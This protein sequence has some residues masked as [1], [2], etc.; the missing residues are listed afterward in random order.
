[1][2]RTT[3]PVLQLDSQ[4]RALP[5]SGDMTEFRGD[6]TGTNMIYAGFAKPGAD[7][8]CNVWTICKMTYDGSSNLTSVKWP[9]NTSGVASNDYEFNWTGRAGYT[10]V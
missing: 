7:E 2:S 6:Y 5:T 1:M 9:K 10:F 3:R 4:G 8:G